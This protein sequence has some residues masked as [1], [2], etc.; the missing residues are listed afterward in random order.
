MVTLK[1]V[2]GDDWEGLY[3]NEE[4]AY[5]DH[6]ISIE[7]FVNM[8]RQNDNISIDDAYETKQEYLNSDGIE[9]TEDC[10]CFPQNH[11]EIIQYIDE[12]KE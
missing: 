2:H 1:I 10:G 4:L 5:E 7:D 3:I 12:Y 8:L 11:E 6:H 9:Y